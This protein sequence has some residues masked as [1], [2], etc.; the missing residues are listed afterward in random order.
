MS[1]LSC[2]EVM[3]WEGDVSLSLC[4]TTPILFCTVCYRYV[5]SSPLI[6]FTDIEISLL[7]PLSITSYVISPIVISICICDISWTLDAHPISYS[8]AP[9]SKQRCTLLINFTILK[10]MSYL[11]VQLYHITTTP[12]HLN[13]GHISSH[14]FSVERN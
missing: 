5:E 14:H 6:L 10:Y 11:P 12:Y 13:F 4:A 2:L 3:L 1:F 7:S 8:H 9:E